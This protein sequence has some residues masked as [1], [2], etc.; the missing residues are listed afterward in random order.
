VD[1]LWGELTYLAYHLHWQ[2]DPLLDLEHGDRTQ[3]I[4]EVAQLNERA[5]QGVSD[6]R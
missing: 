3:L 5:W 4:R 1:E 2:L 6:G